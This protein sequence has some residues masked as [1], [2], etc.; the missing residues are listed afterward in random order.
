MNLFDA[1]HQFIIDECKIEKHIV[2]QC[3]KVFERKFEESYAKMMEDSSK[4]EIDLV[5]KCAL[6]F[7]KVFENTMIDI[8][9]VNFK[10]VL[11]D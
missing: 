8:I 4:I 6:T 11:I 1:L 10:N 2:F 5:W 9:K 3:I 7:Y